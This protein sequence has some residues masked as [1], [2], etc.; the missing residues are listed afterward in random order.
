MCG[1]IRI[2][3]VYFYGRHVNLVWYG[4]NEIRMKTK[5]DSGSVLWSMGYIM[6]L[7]WMW[8][9]EFF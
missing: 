7:N 2:R 1:R 3:R 9:E 6:I 4:R 5:G 8:L